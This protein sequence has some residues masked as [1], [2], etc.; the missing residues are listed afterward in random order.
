MNRVVAIDGPA[1]AGK[2]TISKGLA[3]RL[4]I[5]YLDTGAMYRAMAVLALDNRIDLTDEAT[6]VEHV[7]RSS[8]FVG[9]ETVTV[10]GVDVTARIREQ[11]ATQAAS[12]VA[13]M[14]GVRNHLRRLQR[15]WAEQMGGGV[16]EGRDIGTVVFP[17]A[18]L[19]VFLTATPHERA[20][21]RVAQHGGDIEEVAK[22]IA[23]RDDRDSNR[24]DGPLRVAADS[25]LVDTTNRT[26]EMVVEEIA[27]LFGDRCG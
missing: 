23:E 26:A 8:I 13:A 15:E 2:S 7:S 6:V 20:R 11:D 1:G 21:R 14:S 27:L 25:I 17:E 12:V 9:R 18:C 5:P 3:A 24:V 19:K 10:N 16:I 22:A 4:G